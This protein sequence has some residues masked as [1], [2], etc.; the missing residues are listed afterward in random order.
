[1]LVVVGHQFLGRSVHA[2]T[3][4]HL[5]LIFGQLGLQFYELLQVRLNRLVVQNHATRRGAMPV[6]RDLRL[7]VFDR[8]TKIRD[9]LPI[10]RLRHGV[11]TSKREAS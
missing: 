10:L 7:P 5:L 9:L 3:V 8:L 4:G 11:E 6:L 2:F 1:M